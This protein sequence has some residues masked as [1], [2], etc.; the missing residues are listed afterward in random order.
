MYVYNSIIKLELPWININLKKDNYENPE[1]RIDK[2][3]F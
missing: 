1:F 3:Y 2:R